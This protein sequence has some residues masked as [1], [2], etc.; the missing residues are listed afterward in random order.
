MICLYLL[1]PPVLASLGASP[2]SAMTAGGRVCLSSYR[3]HDI[4]SLLTVLR[5]EAEHCAQKRDVGDC[6]PEGGEI[7]ERPPLSRGELRRDERR[8][9]RSEAC[10]SAISVS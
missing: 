6:H 2:A 9:E 7:V 8:R 10:R 3:G 4:Y 5:F 1:P